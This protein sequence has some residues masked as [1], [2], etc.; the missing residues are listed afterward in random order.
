MGRYQPLLLPKRPEPYPGRP[1]FAESARASLGHSLGQLP[2][3]VV[4][5]AV[6]G[7]IGGYLSKLHDDRV[8]EAAKA[9]NEQQAGIEADQLGL[10][11]VLADR[12]RA[13]ADIAAVNAAAARG[14]MLKEQYVQPIQPAPFPKE[15]APSPSPAPLTDASDAGDRAIAARQETAAL[16]DKADAQTARGALMAKIP[17]ASRLRIK[18]ALGLAE[19]ARS[20]QD[21]GLLDAQASV[22]KDTASTIG[23]ASENVKGANDFA[24]RSRLAGI[25]GAIG[26]GDVKAR[27]PLS[28]AAVA[29]PGVKWRDQTQQLAEELNTLLASGFSEDLARVHAVDSLLGIAKEQ[30][31]FANNG[32]KSMAEGGTVVNSAAFAAN[33][34]ASQ[35]IDMVLK[36]LPPVGGRGAPP[37][38][39]EYLQKYGAASRETAA[40]EARRMQ[41]I[42]QDPQF[43]GYTD[44]Q[45]MTM[46][47]EFAAAYKR[48]QAALTAAEKYSAQHQA[49]YSLPLAESLTGQE[50][51]YGQAAGGAEAKVD[52]PAPGTTSEQFKMGAEEGRQNEA[53]SRG[54]TNAVNAYRSALAQGDPTAIAVTKANL[55]RVYPEFERDPEVIQALQDATR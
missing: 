37:L 54:V 6:E 32:L 42:R 30:S 45:L 44:S 18:G 33:Q 40:L 17:R 46:N 22:A 29:D 55:R 28:T 53:R 14:R 12:E 20:P 24:N 4:G 34:R 36:T 31:D 51:A 11:T 25:S 49:S 41:V 23:A 47:R 10:K 38:S 15:A 35:A 21:Q 7:G 1:T 2:G 9:A 43:A 50:A 16:L 13:N 5:A 8:A 3:A 39:P 19:S 26:L 52:F 48:Q 27:P